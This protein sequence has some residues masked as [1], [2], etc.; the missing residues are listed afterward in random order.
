[1]LLLIAALLL[2]LLARLGTSLVGKDIGATSR[3]RRKLH[4][5]CMVKDDKKEKQQQQRNNLIDYKEFGR[6]EPVAK[7]LDSATGDFA[8]SYADTRPYSP[9]DPVG[10][11]FLATNIIFLVAGT[12]LLL[13]GTKL[14]TSLNIFSVAGFLVDVAGLFSCKYHYDQLSEPFPSMRVRLSLLADYIAAV[15]ACGGTVGTFLQYYSSSPDAMPYFYLSLASMGVMSLLLS[16]RYEAGL[17]Y[18]IFHGLWHI[19]SGLATVEMSRLISP[20]M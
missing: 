13:S 15:F 8:L 14:T 5:N 1:M 19:F 17:T 20:A 4:H 12:E 16:W 11:A 18:I 7:I 10:F 6:L 2:L 3:S 9:E